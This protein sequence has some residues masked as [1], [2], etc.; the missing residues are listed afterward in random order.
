MRLCIRHTTFL[1]AYLAIFISS[2]VYAETIALIPKATLYPFWQKMHEGAQQAA[3]ESEVLLIW[4]GPK[5]E[6]K[7]D[8]Q[9]HLI[10]YYCNGKFKKADALI[11]APTDKKKLVASVEL[12]IKNHCPVVIIDSP[13]ESDKPATYISTNNYQAGRMAAKAL[14][15]A[16]KYKGNVI[17]VRL[18]EGDGSTE[19]RE[20]GFTDWMNKNAPEIKIVGSIN[21]EGNARKALENSTRLFEDHPETN[22]IFS[23]NEWGSNGMLKVLQQKEVAGKIKFIGF[24]YNKELLEGLQ[25]GHLNGLVIQ[26]PHQMGY[27]GVKTAIKIIHGMKV[28]KRIESPFLILTPEIANSPDKLARII[29]KR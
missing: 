20:K 14:A 28:P 27:L 7:V 2:Q 21:S 13:I 11:L 22:G 3:E 9:K 23:S 24:D 8:A 6:G 29:H 15:K 25:N 10:N 5:T 4:R 17:I 1:M 18:L 26:R 16:M 12:A 19:L